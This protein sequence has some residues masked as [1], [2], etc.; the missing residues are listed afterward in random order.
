MRES[1]ANAFDGLYHT[2]IG[3]STGKVDTILP[4]FSEGLPFLY[5][6][7]SSSLLSFP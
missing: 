3:P 1:E 7:S 4:Y 6:F 2:L 5:L